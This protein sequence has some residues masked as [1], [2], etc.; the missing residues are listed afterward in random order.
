MFNDIIKKFLNALHV[1][2]AL[3]PILIFFFTCKH[4]KT[5]LSLV[6]IFFYYGSS[7]LGFY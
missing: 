6:I 3:V 4:S 1:S 2:M 7:S 5:I